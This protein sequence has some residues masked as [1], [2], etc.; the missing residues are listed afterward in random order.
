MSLSRL[1]DLPHSRVLLVLGIVLACVAGFRE[2]GFDLDSLPYLDSYNEFA[3]LLHSNYLNREPSFWLLTWITRLVPGDG[4]RLLLLMYAGIGMGINVLAI[5]RLTPYPVL[6]LLCFTLLYFPLHTMTQIRA[7]VACAIFLWAIPE[8]VSRDLR[9]FLLKAALATMFHYS[10]IVMVA[11][12]LIR[13]ERLNARFYLLLPLVA[14]AI[15]FS[16]ALLLGVVQQVANAI[17][18]IF[19]S[20]VLM[21]ISL[22]DADTG[23]AINLFSLYYVSVLAV[24]YIVFLNIDKFKGVYDVILIKL[25]GWSLAIYYVMSF[26]PVLA[27]R[28]SEIFGVVIILVVP[29]VVYRFQD[30]KV[31]LI[32]ASVWMGVIFFN[33]VFVHQ[34]FNF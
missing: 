24:Y 19:G 11:V 25:L 15:S 34:L 14:L 26:L 18:G 33:N 28:V 29:A 12:Y 10:A 7:S 4:F 8:I 27:V 21:Y 5:R 6:A 23:V 1:T 32:V 20:K 2:V 16:N 13:Q 9:G 30:R 3:G 22:L 17:P 31:A